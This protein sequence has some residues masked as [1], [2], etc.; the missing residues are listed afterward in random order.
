MHNLIHGRVKCSELLNRL[1]LYAPPVATRSN[2]LFGIPRAR[3][4]YKRRMW[5]HALPEICNSKKL[6]VLARIKTALAHKPQP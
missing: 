2:T 3:T 4:D 5:H 1:S 6:T